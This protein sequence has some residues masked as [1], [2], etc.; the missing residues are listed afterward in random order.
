MFSFCI[1]VAINWI[2]FI[3][4][5]M[6]KYSFIKLQID[7]FRCCTIICI[8]R[9]ADMLLFSFLDHFHPILKLWH[10]FVFDC[11]QMYFTFTV[12]SLIMWIISVLSLMTMTIGNAYPVVG[13]IQSRT[14]TWMKNME[15][16]RLEPCIMIQSKFET[17]VYGVRKKWLC[18]GFIL[19]GFFTLWFVVF[20]WNFNN[21]NWEYF[22]VDMFHITII[23]TYVDGFILIVY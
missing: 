2:Y 23:V 19:W 8:M 11:K 5:W 15:I 21:N 14:C 17:L 9:Y 16:M 18:F 6:H 20:R 1:C 10:A 22:H 3:K 4:I 12:C 13:I 7:T